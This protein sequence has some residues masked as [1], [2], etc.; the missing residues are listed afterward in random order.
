MNSIDYVGYGRHP[1]EF[2]WPGNSTLAL[3]IV[4]NFEEGGEH[5]MSKDGM[6]EGGIGEFPPVDIEAEDVGLASAYAYAQRVGIWRVL[7]TLSRHRVRATFFAVARALELNPEATEAIV[8]AGHEICDHGYTWTELFRMSE[9]QELEEIRKSIEAIEGGLTGQRPVG[10][11]AREPSERTLKLLSRFENFIYDSDAYDDDIPYR[12]AGSRL[13]IVPYTPDA[14]DFH[15]LYPMNRFDNSD[16]FLRYLIDTFDTLY[17]ESKERPKMM[18]AAFHVRITGRP[19][20]IKALSS[21]LDYVKGKQGVWIARR[22]EIARF[23]I[24]R[25]LPRL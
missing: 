21:F 15:F 17:E 25:V 3:S 13:I 1:P 14:N 11:Y 10:F 19:G 22:D 16:A 9:E 4:V 5:S 12:P 24:E 6:V 8:Q 18:S 7:D 2:R 23:W 20:R